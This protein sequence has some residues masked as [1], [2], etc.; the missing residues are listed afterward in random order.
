MAVL[1]NKIKGDDIIYSKIT[2]NRP[3][4]IGT[5]LMTMALVVSAMAVLHVFQTE[6]DESSAQ[7]ISSGY[8]GP[9]ATYTLYTDG[10]LEITGSGEM[11]QYGGPIRAPWYVDRD[12]VT[13]IVIGDNITKLG[14]WAFIKCKHVTELTLPITLN[15]VASDMYAAFAGLTHIEKINFTCGNGGRGYDYAAYEGSDSWYQNTPWYQ[16]RDALK[17]INFADGIT[18]IGSDSFRELNIT[19]I[20]IPDSVVALGNHCFFGCTELT[21]LTLPI[22]LNSYGNSTYPAFKNCTVLQKIT[23]TKGNGSSFEYSNWRGAYCTNLT[24]WNMNYDIPKTLIIADD[25]TQP[26]KYMFKGSNIKELTVPA[27]L[28]FGGSSDLYG[29]TDNLEKLTITKGSGAKTDYASF[30]TGGSGAWNKTSSSRCPWD[31]AIHLKTVIVKEG[32][33]YL[34]SFM[35]YKC[36]MESLVLPNSLASFGSCAFYN[37]TVKKLTAPASLN[38]TWLEKFPAFREVSGLECVTIT[39]GSGYGFDYATDKGN[40]CWYQLTPWYQCRNTMKEVNFTEGITHIGSNAFR[41]LN[42]SSAW[43]PSTVGSVGVSAFEG[44]TSLATLYLGC[45]VNS[46]GKA[47]FRG[48]TPSFVTIPDSVTYL[49][50]GAFDS[51]FY[52]TDGIDELEHTVENLAGS[53]FEK[54]DDKL[55]KESSKCGEG[56]TYKLDRYTRTLTISGTGQM[57]D[58]S[59][60]TAPWYQHWDIISSVRIGDSVTSIGEYAFCGCRS[61][62]SVTIPDSVESVGGHAFEE[63]VA[64]TSVTIPDSVTSLGDQIFFGCRSLTSVTIPDSIESIGSYTFRG[65]TSL[66][67]LSLP[68]S[69]RSIGEYAFYYCTSLTSVTIPDSVEFLGGSA[70]SDCTSLTSVHLPNSLASLE[71]YVFYNCSGLSSID[72]PDSVTSIGTHAF[73]GC[74]SLTSVIVPD[75]VTSF[76]T[77]VFAL[78]SSLAALDLGNSVETIEASAFR[79]CTSL[80]SVT[81]PDSVEF[82]GENAFRDCASLTS[83]HLSYSLASLQAGVFYNCSGLISVAIPDSVKFIGNYTFYNCSGLTSAVVPD[84]VTF[85]GNY[86]FN[87][88]TSLTVLSLPNTLEMI[89]SSA[90]SGCTSLISASLPNSVYSLGTNAFSGCSSLTTLNLGK[91]V[92]TIGDS[93]FKSCTSLTTLT[94]PGS[95]TSIGDSAFD[96]KFYDLSGENE[97]EPTAANIAGSTFNKVDD[98]FIKRTESG[99]CGKT[100]SYEFDLST[101]VLVIG[102]SGRMYSYSS[103]SA[104]WFSYRGSIRSVEIADSVKSIGD[105]AFEGIDAIDSVIIP[106]SVETV[107]VFVFAGCTELATIKLGKS[108]RSLDTAAFEGCSS[109]SSLVVSDGNS[110]YSSVDGVLFSKDKGTLIQ[111][112]VAKVDASYEIPDSVTTIGSFAFRGCIYL[113]SIVIPDFV[114]TVEEDAFDMDF[115][116]TDDKTELGLTAEDLAGSTFDSKDGKWIRQAFIPPVDP[117]IVRG[118]CGE[119]VTYELDLSSGVLTI[120]G[121]GQMSSYSKGEAPWLSQRDSIESIEI[122][123]SVKSIGDHAFDGITNIDAITVPDSVETIGASAFEG[124]TELATIKLGKSVDYIDRSAFG[125][126]TSLASYVVSEGSSRYISVDGVLF[127]KDEG[128]LIQYPVAKADPSYQIPATVKTIASSAFKGCT[129]LT[130]IT[131]PDSVENVEAGAFDMVFYDTDGE[132]ELGQ[133]A[134][135]LGG[136]TL[137][138]IGDKWVKHK[139]SGICGEGVTYELDLSTGALTISG[140]GQVSSYSKGEAPWF[141]HRDSIKSIKIADAVTSIGDFAFEGTSSIESISIPDSVETI[142]ASA[143]EGCSSLATVILGRS[144]NSIGES[145][146]GGCTLLTSYAVSEDNSTYS[147]IDGVLFSKDGTLLIQ[148]PAA[149]TDPSYQIPATVKTIASSAFKGCT[150]L[151]SITI[152]D[153]VET[154]EE[155]AFDTIFYDPADENLLEPTVENLGGSILHYVEDKWVKYME[156]GICGEGVAYELD[157]F[158]CVLTISGSGEIKPYPPGNAPWFSHNDSIESIEIADTVTSI[159]DHAFEGIINIDSVIIPDSVE[160]IGA[161]AFEDCSN[162]AAVKFGKSVN[163][164]DRSAFGGCTLLASYAVSENNGTYTSI[165][166]VLFS[167]DGTI[168]IQYPVA[169]ADPSYEIPVSVKTIMSSAFKGCI[170]LASITIPDSVTSIDA[171]AFDMIFYDPADENIL[172]PTVENLACSTFSNVDGKFTKQWESGKCGDTVTYE[173]E[174]SK[175]TLTIGGSGKMSSYSDDEAPWHSY[176][177]FIRSVEIADTVTSIG[178]HAFEGIIN[179]DSVIIPD[180]VETIGNHAFEGCSNLTAIK[181]GKSVNSFDMSAFEGCTSL[182]SYVVSENNG[183]YTSIDGVL[184]SKDEGSLIQYPVAKADASYEIP[185]TVRTIGSSAF[186]GCALLATITILD[187]VT[188]IEAGA[189]DTVFYD[190]DGETELDQTV[191]NLVGSTFKNI[192]GKWIRQA[193]A[194]SENPDIVSGECGEGVTYELDLFDGTLTII[195]SGKMDSY[196]GGEAPWSPYIDSIRSVEIADSVNSIGDF[197]FEG[198]II[199][200]SVTISDSVEAIGS[201]AFKGCTSLKSVVIPDSV[202]SL[203][204]YAF[205]G[206]TVL[207]AVDLSNSLTS[208]EAGIFCNCSGLTCAIVT[209]S[210]ETIGA[211]AFEGCTELATVKLGKSVNSLDT[212][213]FEGCSSLASFVVSDGN[214]TFTSIDGV[215]FSKDETALIQYPVAKEGTSYEMSD[216]VKTIESS[217][218]CG[219]I[220]LTSI[221]ISDSVETVEEGAFDMIFYDPAGEK[222]L[223]PTTSNLAGSTFKNIDGKWI[224]QDS[225][226][227]PD[228][229][230]SPSDTGSGNGSMMIHLISAMVVVI[231]LF[232]AVAVVKKRYA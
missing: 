107:G 140:S 91:S 110:S 151:T 35:F 124:C 211:S 55:V 190:T 153:S 39:P 187:S 105:F 169:K 192:D 73:C 204:A 42:I 80:T 218:F 83:V 182:A 46:I 138:Y 6:T 134:E 69:L 152:P 33:T 205:S 112:P 150:T 77:Y 183:T 12:E 60:G 143:F 5:L 180:S 63:C 99:M 207:T 50:D 72:I 224:R 9:S 148:Y 145:A 67:T 106:D 223:E 96:G 136:S 25:V 11:Y 109:L 123:D 61:L 88:C 84:S 214:S 208:L 23:L 95:V 7:V 163:S 71:A 198:L 116:D 14:A 59:V 51:K 160:T 133:T 135:D 203:G 137:H 45:S 232:V 49:G 166:G 3:L 13:S 43:I 127:S 78:C 53:T 189:F 209:D 76:G 97:L 103:G 90:F 21:N 102:G 87:D 221:T 165:D 164:F 178:D 16:S 167:K 181:L 170:F 177:D 219:C 129:T 15:S 10:T 20:V 147:S 111:Y 22:S 128:T 118:K 52:D 74:D 188:S 4:K 175:G 197:A 156:F 93:A 122:A 75:S 44:C 57:S 41:N 104:P 168:L 81:V 82:L 161:S 86:A 149:K 144:V 27:G 113:T 139:G 226:P 215:L 17:E 174:L 132:T 38:T 121:S 146:F 70:F 227:L 130:S 30:G 193:S 31:W 101:G 47:A 228:P 200:E 172:E 220:L 79:G 141:S 159:G 155:G 126:C 19:S 191:E 119:G 85:I 94:I 171:G 34:G 32:V 154:V 125:G 222:V 29:T 36:E 131:I 37:C 68:G 196:S 162:L 158:T 157:L 66:A 28:Y 56:V 2:P 117:E 54:V 1:H 225:V 194:P 65:C 210:V 40:N 179:I 58:F 195:G 186:K 89:F 206:C 185:A 142:G 213:A 231:T 18:G 100:V 173:L 217:A 114:E 92:E 24:P 8:C 62:T 199:L 64:I 176:I 98:K 201:S 184:F 230:P 26:S 120:S 108:V 229:S 115:Y 216:T 212:A 202:R 48:C